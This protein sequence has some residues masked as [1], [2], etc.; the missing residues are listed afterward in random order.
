MLKTISA[1]LVA[2]SV[3]AAPALAGTPGK[4]A[5]APVSQ[6]PQAPVIKAEGKRRR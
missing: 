2:V 6:D 1:A 5:Q 3:L 4:T